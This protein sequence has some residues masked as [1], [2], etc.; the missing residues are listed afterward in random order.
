MSA[1]LEWREWMA[2]TDVALYRLTGLRSDR[3]ARWDY[4]GAFENGLTPE[5]AADRAAVEAD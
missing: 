1:A 4:L 2:E 5:A 3:L